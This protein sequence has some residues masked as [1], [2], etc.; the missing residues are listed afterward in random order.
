M[1]ALRQEYEAKFA[2]L[3]AERDAAEE[4]YDRLM[5]G[6][7]SGEHPELNQLMKDKY[8]EE[9]ELTKSL[10]Q[11]DFDAQMKEEKKKFVEK[12]RKLMTDFMGDREKE[13]EEA[14]RRHT[15]EMEQLRENLNRE[16]EEKISAYEQ[17]NVRLSRDLDLL[18]DV[19][20]EERDNQP[21]SNDSTLPEIEDITLTFQEQLHNAQQTVP[22]TSE[23]VDC[24]DTS[25]PVR[26]A[27]SVE[28]GVQYEYEE[29][30]EETEAE[31]AP[32]RQ[33]R[34]FAD[35]VKSPTPASAQDM[36][37]TVEQLT[38][39]VE[40]L[41]LQ[42]VQQQQ[43]GAKTPTRSP[44]H[45]PENDTLKDEDSALVAMLQSDL[46]RISAERENV[47]RTNDRLL[48]LLSDSV[49]TYV[50][51]EDTINRKL[52]LVVSGA[53]PRSGAGEA[54]GG[55]AGS[56]PTSRP[57]SR[58]GS[59]ETVSHLGREDSPALDRKGATP[60]PDTS[61]DSHHLEDTSIL[62]NATDEGL[63]ISHR[64][65]ESIFVG[66]D[67]DAE[68]EEILTDA[69]SRLTNAVGQLLELMER[70]TVQLMEAK[71][72][73]QELLDTLAARGQELESTASRNT[74]L[75]SQLAAEIQAKDYLGLELH[76]AEGL[77]AGY[78]AER[79]SLESQL[80]N[81]EEQ[82]EAL[83]GDLDATRSRLEEFQRSQ[84][85]MESVRQDLGR[86]QELL[87]D[88]AG[89][90]M[91]VE[92][93]QAPSP[94]GETTPPALLK[95]VDSLNQEKRE[96]AEQ[97]QHQLDLSRRRLA[98]LETLAEDGE[99]RHEA[100][101]EERAR[102]VEDLR[103]Q[104][105]NTERQLKASKAF[106]AEQMA[107]REQEREE[108]Q[109]EVERLEELMQGKDKSA[110]SQERLQTEIADLT[111]QLH[112]RMTSQSSMHQRTLELQKALEDKELSAHDLKLFVE[113]DDK[114]THHA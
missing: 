77:I 29:S 92:E 114:L 64:L 78:S 106:V 30:E 10:I 52:S 18:R 113:R 43:D 47:Q 48:S 94:Q 13:E 107:E 103:L 90:E 93:Q 14:N 81:L 9:L 44:Q 49:K 76:K 89:Q 4:R 28:A 2:Q 100:Q 83:I 46:E 26:R 16:Y 27:E 35:V 73:Q 74:E 8:D 88:N 32:T 102:Q 61:Q 60:D 111:E 11:Q 3:R 39:Q 58:P 95:E 7:Q 87:R 37:F 31:R 84:V 72:T 69:R 66:P 91:Q 21:S 98:E 79:E 45:S 97:L 19:S 108:H 15:E 80:Q 56:R 110:N 25:T 55:G 96:L 20:Q 71:A 6:V 112:A 105:D 109:R 17:E 86:Q 23:Q 22:S 51:V 70:S 68:G 67:L 63:E 62:S 36:E 42:L 82:R 85:E 59:V 101:L 12:H 53:T 33:L 41:T 1:K 34:S 50:G 99:R 75:D 40:R 54:S 57:T 24:R 104:L 38:A 65:A 5:Q